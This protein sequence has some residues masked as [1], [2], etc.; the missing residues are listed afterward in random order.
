MA[1]EERKTSAVNER[2]AC[3]E[4]V[5]VKTKQGGYKI[6]EYQERYPDFSD[7]LKGRAMTLK[8]P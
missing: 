2:I 3:T 5:S 7:A 6:R 4:K 1:D 8:R